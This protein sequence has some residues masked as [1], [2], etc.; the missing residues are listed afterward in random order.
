M[1]EVIFLPRNKI[2][3]VKAGTSLL[4]TSIRA[5]VVIPARCGGKAACLMCK[6]KVDDPTTLLPLTQSEKTKLSQEQISENIR[7]ACQAKVFNKKVIVSIPE[8]PLNKV[9]QAQLK[10]ENNNDL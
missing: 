8:S 10:N 5:R 6:V 1:A 7:L 3:K 9:V 4:D 2:I